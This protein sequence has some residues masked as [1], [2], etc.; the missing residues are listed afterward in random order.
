MAALAMPMAR[1]E[2]YDGARMQRFGEET[3]TGEYFGEDTFTESYSLQQE[4]P[5]FSGLPVLGL[6]NP[7]NLALAPLYLS[8]DEAQELDDFIEHQ[9]ALP[10][11]PIQG[12]PRGDRSRLPKKMP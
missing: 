3:L 11:L 9:S 4:P 6:V 12:V 5:T 8:E 10:T 7:L 1:V 2:V